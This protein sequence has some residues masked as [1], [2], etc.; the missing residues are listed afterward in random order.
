MEYIVQTPCGE[1]RGCAGRKGAVAYKG[2]RYATAGRWEYPKQVTGWEGIYDATRF[3]KCSYQAS[4]FT[5]PDDTSFY[6]HE[7]RAG[8]RYEYSEDSLFLNIYTPEKAKTGD[9]LPVLIY[10]HGGAFV[11]GRA[12]EKHFRDP[13]WTDYGVIGVTIH[14]R[15]GPWGFLCLPE[16]K[17]EAGKAGNY[18]LHDQMTAIRW[19]KDN[20]AAFGGDPDNITI[21]GQSAGA[22]SVQQLCLSSVTKGLFQR[23]IMS[24]GGGDVSQLSAGTQE[25][26]YAYWQLF[27]KHT[28]CET[29]A[30]MRALTPQQIKEAFDATKAECRERGYYPVIDGNFL[31]G[32]TEEI[33]A[34][35][36]QHKIPYMIGATSEDMM[37]PELQEQAKVWADRQTENSY[38]WHFNRQL[39]G[40]DKG[41]FHTADIWYWFGTLDR[42]WRPMEEKDYQLSRQMVDYLCSFVRTGD[43]N[44][45]GKQPI[46]RPSCADDPEVML[47]GEQETAMGIPRPKR[48]AENEPERK[49]ESE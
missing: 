12:H 14:Y 29:L 13:V 49:G 47:L 2:I 8:E 7:F 19:I 20:I 34:A 48:E 36:K 10:I 28:G 5:T 17:E 1:V 43:P 21:M 38:V 11:G 9:Q 30:Q 22:A 18:G 31:T 45:S 40:D 42:C 37:L 32:T 3:G 39:P 26:R 15:L 16:L 6:N 27:R 41:A 24:S 23:A 46:W 33:L 25:E 35:G 44:H 4:A